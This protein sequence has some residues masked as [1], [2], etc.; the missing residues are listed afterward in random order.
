MFDSI[1][2]NTQTGSDAPD[3]GLL[4]ETLIF[5]D[6]VNLIV[7]PVHPTSLL[8][9][10]GHDLLGD[11]F[12]MSA[13]SMTYVENHSGIRT[14]NAGTPHETHHFVTFGS[15]SQLLQNILPATLKEL[16]GK[17]GKAR[18]VS[19]S[20]KR[21]VAVLSH[22]QSINDRSLDDASSGDHVTFS[23]AG[24]LR[25]LVPEYEL[26]DPFQFEVLR[27]GAELRVVTNIDFSVVNA[28]YH[29]RVDP[30][31]SVITPA[32]LLSYIHSATADLE[33]AASANSEIA[34]SPAGLRIVTDRIESLV[35]RT[36]SETSIS[37]FQD[38]I[39]DDGRAI[40]EAVNHGNKS[41][42]DVADLV[43][44]AREFKAWVKSKPEDADLR[45]A[46]LAEVS[47]LGWSEKLPQKTSRFAIFGA[48]STA[49][50][51]LATPAIGAV[52]GLGLSA[53]DYFLV[54]R[55]A[56]GWKPNQFVQGPLADF[57]Q[58]ARRTP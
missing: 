41:M 42:K 36:Q 1:T 38:F 19:E 31:H 25:F 56:N 43:V 55:L 46:Y 21:H 47:R 28:F 2:V 44:K 51:F 17:E 11:L 32:F 8:R 3:I 16:I 54:D 57:V 53:V 9:V 18:R 45:K 37:A 30:K 40:R 6:R 10:C 4:A 33:I 58:A 23:A 35:R 22:P 48:V 39:F 5:Y 15:P 52:A 24:V 29:S 7:G 50:S 26:P 14:T 20:L 13:L 12:D 27:D 49:L 34:L